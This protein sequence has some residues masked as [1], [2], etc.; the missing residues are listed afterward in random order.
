MTKPL[1]PPQYVN[2]PTTL[3]YADLPRAVIVTGLR[4]TGLAWQHHYERTDPIDTTDLCAICDIGRSQLYD[5]LS[6]LLDAGMLQYTKMAGQFIFTFHRDRP[7]PVFRTDGALSAA[8]YPDTESSE[9]QQQQYSHGFD[10]EGGCG[11]VAAPSSLPDWGQ[12][13]AALDRAGVREPARSEIAILEHATAAY[14]ETWAAWFCTQTE[15]GVGALIAQ[16]RAGVPAPDLG[17]DYISGAYSQYI[18]H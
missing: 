15:L 6:Q 10:F 5:H 16:L 8:D 13:L 17:R 3:A 18:Q 14:L 4:I 11:G 1:L 12:R 2:I 9:I 7:S